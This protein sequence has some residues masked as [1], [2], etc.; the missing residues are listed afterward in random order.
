MMA[1]FTGSCLC[2]ACFAAAIEC[3]GKGW[4]AGMELLTRLLIELQA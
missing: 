2:G 3:V 4:D 1:G